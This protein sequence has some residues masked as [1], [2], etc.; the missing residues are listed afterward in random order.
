MRRP[1]VLGL[2]VSSGSDSIRR[3]PR[4]GQ[5]DDGPPGLETVLDVVVGDLAA[6]DDEGQRR[7]AIGNGRR[8]EG[9]P[10]RL[11]TP[12]VSRNQDHLG[13]VGPGR[14]PGP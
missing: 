1:R 12:V 5:D 6:V 2:T 14:R 9:E 7:L 4:P 13:V 3:S 11:V 8:D 10:G